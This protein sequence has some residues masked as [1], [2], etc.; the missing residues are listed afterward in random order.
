MHIEKFITGP[1]E[2][3]TYL[4]CGNDT[5]AICID[6][7]TGCEEIIDYCKTN[8]LTISAIV[9]TH[10][11]FDHILGIDEIQKAFPAAGVYIHP[12]DRSFLTNAEQNGAVLIGSSYTY[13]G[14]VNELAEGECCIAGFSFK[15]LHVPGHTPGGCAFVFKD[16]D[17]IHC[18]S[19]DSLFAGSVG[20][21]DF[22]LGDTDLLIQSIRDKLMTLT[23]DTV[24]YP[25]HGGRTTIGRERRLNP[26]LT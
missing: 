18:I 3:N 15:V 14:A 13:T 6:P 5:R 20:R 16:G 1:I 22:P 10:G 21:T 19:G 12:A 2:N 7:S 24:V 8:A 26:F 25:G 9:L 11:H 23:D 17:A 4:L